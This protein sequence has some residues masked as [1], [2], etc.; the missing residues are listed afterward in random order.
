MCY[1]S[2]RPG[3]NADVQAIHGI[4]AANLPPGYL[5]P[6]Q[7]LAAPHRCTRQG[8]ETAGVYA[9]GVVGQARA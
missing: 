9:L 1:F 8:A 5:D 3:E 2:G 7:R 6:V 4:P